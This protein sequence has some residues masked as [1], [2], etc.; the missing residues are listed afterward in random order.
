M[1]VRYEDWN[2]TG[3]RSGRGATPQVCDK[4]R[5]YSS[6]INVM[7]APPEHDRAASFSTAAGCRH[8]FRM[9]TSRWE[10]IKS[11]F[12]AALELPEE[13]RP[14]FVVKACGGDIEIQAEVMTLLAANK[15]MGSFLNDPSTQGFSVLSSIRIQNSLRPGEILCE[16]FEI[17]RLLGVGGMGRV[18]EAR[19]LD[20]GV[21][22]ALKTVRPEISSDPRTIELFKH[23]IQL[24]RQVTHLN[25]CRIFDM[26]RDKSATSQVTFLTMELLEGET[27]ESR[28][29]RD[30][31]ISAGEALPMVRQMADGLAAIHEM[32]V[33]HRDFKPSNVLLVTSGARVRVVIT[34]FG[35]AR[36]K[37]LAVVSESGGGPRTL[38]SL[39]GTPAY[40]APEQLL[41][42]PISPATDIYALGLVLHKMLIGTLPYGVGSEMTVAKDAITGPV[43]PPPLH[44]SS[45]DPAWER[46]ITRCLD[47]DPEL[48]FQTAGEMIQAIESRAGGSHT[49]ATVANGAMASP[50]KQPAANRGRRI[51]SI[52][53]WTLAA[54]ILLAAAMAAID[55]VARRQHGSATALDLT[56]AS[57]DPG[58]SWGPSLS[59]DGNLAAFSSDREGPG[60]LNV[61]VKNLSD[62]SMIQLTYDGS[63]ATTPAISPDGSLVA[64]R[65][66]RNGGGIYVAPVKG[67]QSR[68]LAPLG[69][70]PAFSP[71]GSKI[72]YWVGQEYNLDDGFIAGAKVFVISPQGGFQTQIAPQFA[73]A[74]YP[75]WSSDGR[76]ILFQGAPRPKATF[77]EAS[78]WWVL[79]RL[80]NT[81]IP[82]G[83]FSILRQNGLILYGCRFYWSGRTI[84]FAARKSFSANIWAL[85]LLDNHRATLPV[86]RLTMGTNDEIEPWVSPTGKL[87]LASTNASIAIWK[88]LL[89][90]KPGEVP[91]QVTSS[92]VVD[93][94]LSV[95][96]DGNKLAFHRRTGQQ[97]ETILKDMQTGEE[98]DI[99]IPGKALPIVSDDGQAVAY[100]VKQE[101]KRRIYLYLVPSGKSELIC[102]DCGPLMALSQDRNRFLY[103]KDDN[104]IG[105]MN[106]AN[107]RSSEAVAG[108]KTNIEQARF[109]PDE[110]WLAFISIV[111]QQHAQINVA[112][113]E[114]DRPA[115]PAS[116][117]P[118][119]DGIGLDLRPTWA[120]D[121]NSLFFISNRDGS[122]CIWQLRLDPVTRHPLGNPMPVQHFHHTRQSPTDLSIGAMGLSRGGNALFIDLNDLKGNIF[123]ADLK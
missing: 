35:L 4:V 58:L 93:T 117:I 123:T 77:G 101:G 37:A 118:I 86:R 122:F 19:D 44:L 50:A 115:L 5:L 43:L 26:E 78:D 72:T 46:A 12:G 48:R 17:I 52:A 83:A 25:V 111:D 106:A 119:S 113:A 15:S 105:M 114:K 108:D 10:Q 112:H 55:F 79:P 47:A 18:Y 51:R 73:D 11:I 110:K 31:P 67:G 84:F 42:G 120:A 75:T 71:D 64:Y 21:R 92:S 29:Q 23:E 13:E 81:P 24:A 103:G 89:P 65:S 82:T 62:S 1:C 99:P 60:N 57:N 53:A 33:I 61:W 85:D 45:L 70:N 40:M 38:T 54:I 66:E 6:R 68:L 91:A 41:G 104:T 69:R 94:L 76:A 100:S 121:G 116:W 56:A 20:L 39:A 97:E 90:P 9:I 8:E 7:L 2:V 98:T 49:L 63:N 30:G 87:A 28:I 3:G 14:V 34:D 16:R 96:S 95:S 80:S 59:A 102:D 74:R 88:V 36:A 27:L 107:H 22:V 109:S 32:G